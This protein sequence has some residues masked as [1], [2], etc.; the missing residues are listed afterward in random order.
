[1]DKINKKIT[2]IYI[3]MKNINSFANIKVILI[4][5]DNWIVSLQPTVNNQLCLITQSLFYLTKHTVKKLA[6]HSNFIKKKITNN[7]NIQAGLPLLKLIS[8]CW[9]T[10]F[11]QYKPVYSDK[12]DKKNNAIQKNAS[13]KVLM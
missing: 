11:F 3:I 9:I 4:K 6:W 10:L 1:M 5:I 12:N 8:I 2:R 7:S 13:V